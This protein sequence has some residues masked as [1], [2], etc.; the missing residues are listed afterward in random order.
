MDCRPI[1]DWP[2]SAKR[3]ALNFAFSSSTLVMST[4]ARH[5]VMSLPIPTANAEQPTIHNPGVLCNR[6]L[7]VLY[8]CSEM[9]R[10]SHYFLP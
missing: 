3:A 1:G 8:G 10:L 7:T 9:P 6:A 5:V 4:D 2:T